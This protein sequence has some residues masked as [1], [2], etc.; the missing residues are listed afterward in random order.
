VET[1]RQFGSELRVFDGSKLLEAPE[2]LTLDPEREKQMRADEAELEVWLRARGGQPWFEG[3]VM[4]CVERFPRLDRF[5]VSAVIYKLRDEQ[6][7]RDA[8]QY[9]EES[10]RRFGVDLSKLSVEELR[11]MIRRYWVNAKKS[12]EKR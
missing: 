8:Q 7:A 10:V 2:T 9:A 6:S 12:L 11:A 5:Q 4:E 1:G 3:I